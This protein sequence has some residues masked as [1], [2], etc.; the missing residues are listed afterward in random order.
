[1]GEENRQVTLSFVEQDLTERGATSLRGA[2][3]R[4]NLFIAGRNLSGFDSFFE[5]IT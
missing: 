4:G 2:Q 1:L 3:R 5:N